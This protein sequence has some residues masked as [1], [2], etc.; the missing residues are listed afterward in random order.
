MRIEQRC[1]RCGKELGYL[2]KG[3][4]FCETC[5]DIVRDAILEAERFD[6]ELEDLK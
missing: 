6:Y 1:L 4:N 3:T 5:Y 2:Y